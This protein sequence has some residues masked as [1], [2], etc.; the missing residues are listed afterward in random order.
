LQEFGATEMPSRVE[1]NG[2]EN[3][4]SSNIAITES[5]VNSGITKYTCVDHSAIL[6]LE[7]KDN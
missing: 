2:N 6:A 4:S 5:L 7:W 1:R 3:A